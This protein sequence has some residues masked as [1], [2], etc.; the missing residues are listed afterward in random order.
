[1]SRQA[2]DRIVDEYSFQMSDL[3]DR[4]N[5]IQIGNQIGANLI[6]TGFITPVADYH[7]VNIQ[8]IE[9]ETGIVRGGFLVDFRL[10]PDFERRLRSPTASS[11]EVI[12]PEEMPATWSTVATKT[13]IVETFDTGTSRIPLDH[14]EDAWGERIVSTTGKI[15]LEEK[16]GRDG[17]ACARYS[18]GAKLDS[19]DPFRDWEDSD[20]S[21]YLNLRIPQP[22]GDADGIHLS[23]KPIGFSSVDFFLKQTTGAQEVC[24][25]LSCSLNSDEWHDLKIPFYDF[26]PEEKGTEIDPN[27]S[28]HLSI[29]IPYRDNVYQFHFRT[30]TQ[31]EG[32]LLID[33]VG[34][35]QIKGEDDAA[36]LDTFDDEISRIV[37]YG[38][39]YGSSTYFDY[40]VS[41]EGLEKRTPGIEHQQFIIRRAERET[42][43]T[44][45]SVHVHFDVTEE[46]RDL[47]DAEQ[48]LTLFLRATVGKSWRGRETIG[49]SIRSDRLEQ[50]AFEVHDTDRDTYF[51]SDVAVN[52]IWTRIHVRFDQLVSEDATLLESAAVLSRPY[53]SFFFDIPRNALEQSALEGVLDVTLDIDEFILE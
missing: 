6:L 31:M 22:P 18:F 39:I 9:V 14:G 29:G 8:L 48:T 3:A 45:V 16:A 49:F 4:N 35:Y 17:S 50:G 27:R 7:K 1:M 19:A 10:E 23:L 21:C 40:A 42:G 53:L 38:G 52:P 32:S 34:Y 26:Y 43:G 25:R 5:Q 47:I 11:S 46:I 12:R 51:Y 20:L 37:L 36:V 33:N 41:D 28:L 15:A 2:L 30:G 24:F 44:H 13:T